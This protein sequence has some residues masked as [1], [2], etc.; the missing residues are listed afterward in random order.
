[1]KR[2]ILIMASLCLSFWAKGQSKPIPIVPGH[3]DTVYSN[4]LKEK[5]PIWIYTPSFDTSYFT[6][7]QYPVLYVLDGDGYFASLVTMIQQLS[8]INGNTVLPEM[9]IVGI[10]NIHGER[11]RDLTP[12]NSVMDKASGGGENF[13]AFIEKELI[14]YIDKNYATAP[15]RTL[16]GH[17]F[18]GLMVINTLLKHTGLFNAYLALE[19]S[20]FYNNDDLLKQ[21]DKLLQHGSFKGRSLFLG[22]ANTMNPGM[23]TTQVRTDTTELTHHIRSILKLKDNLQKYTANNLRWSYKYYPDDDHSS[24][25]LIGEYDGLRFVFDKNRFPRNQPMN[26]YFDKQYTAVNLKE[27]I[28]AHYKLMSQDMGYEVKPPE[29][30]MNQFGYIFLQQKDY[31]KSAMFFQMNIDYYPQSFNAYDSMGDY[32]LGRNEKSK[33]M[34]YFKKALTCKF[35]PDIK[36]KLDKLEMEKK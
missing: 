15:Y 36:E 9:I 23:D 32:Y 22:I 16:I 17:S 5:R 1:M 2:N 10:P 30:V 35:R 29:F 6:K 34:E 33:A 28:I 21:A 12:S 25:P 7:P 27:M 14:P 4:I 18:G 26:Q 13:T 24:M 11:T 20:M 31:E 3:I 8:A 19:P